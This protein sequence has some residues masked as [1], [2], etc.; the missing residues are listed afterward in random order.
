MTICDNDDDNIMEFLIHDED[1]FTKDLIIIS[2]NL[3]DDS[4]DDDDDDDDAPALLV[5]PNV[6]RRVG[7]APNIERRR[8]FYSHLLFGDFWSSAPIYNATYFKKFSRF[9]SDS[10][11]ILC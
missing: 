4:D 8:V 10:L 2:N 5:P 6:W 3:E 1:D 9:Q 11:M 7:K